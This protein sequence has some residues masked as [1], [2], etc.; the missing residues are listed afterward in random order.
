[1]HRERI[2]R[3]KMMKK[4]IGKA[5]SQGWEFPISTKPKCRIRKKIFMK[6]R[7]TRPKSPKLKAKKSRRKKNRKSVQWRVNKNMKNRMHQ[8]RKLL[9]EKKNR[10]LWSLR[11]NKSLLRRKGLRIGKR[12]ET[13]AKTK[14]YMQKKVRGKRRAVDELMIMERIF[15]WSWW[16][17]WSYCWGQWGLWVLSSFQL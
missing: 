12:K 11:P 4:K 5:K 8:S 17:L 15:S 3:N 2:E 14:P 10:S 7:E 16:V 1:M 9:K 6:S 13:F